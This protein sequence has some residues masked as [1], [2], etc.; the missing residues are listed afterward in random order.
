MTELAM[1]RPPEDTPRS[2][3][4]VLERRVTVTT[5]AVL[6]ALAG[7]A[8]W[9]TVGQSGSM[10]AMVQGFAHV[11][12]AMPFDMTGPV[13]LAM[14]TTMMVA[15]M[16]PA[17]A[18]IVLMHRLVTRRRGE[19]LAPTFAF[20]TSYLVVWSLIGLVPLAVLIGFRQVTHDSAWLDRAGG[21]V[22]LLAGL[23]QFSRWKTTCLR[24]CRTPLSFLLTHDFGGGLG[25]STSP[26]RPATTVT[27][28]ALPFLSFTSCFGTFWLHSMVKCGSANLSARG[29]FNQI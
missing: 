14:W 12:V 29:R 11:G 9:R 17:V 20:G 3:Y 6:L 26:K 24:A 2:A 18:P 21:L 28:E 13:F 10:S 15:M 5:A 25:G 22:L 27:T 19:G 4:R 16:F 8:W 1:P 7:L 23:Y